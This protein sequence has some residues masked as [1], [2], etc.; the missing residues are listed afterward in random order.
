M[1]HDDLPDIPIEYLNLSNRSKNFLKNEGIRTFNSL[2]EFCETKDSKSTFYDP[3]KNIRGLGKKSLLEINSLINVFDCEIFF[4]ENPELLVLLQNNK[5]P[6]EFASIHIDR[7]D[8][9][10]RS[11]NALQNNSITNLGQL[12]LFTIEELKNFKNMGKKSVY[13]IKD[14][15]SKFNLKLNT[16]NKEDF[17]INNISD[18]IDEI[19]KKKKFNRVKELLLKRIFQSKTLNEVGEIAGVTRERIRQI[20]KD[21]FESL[22]KLIG[23]SYKK[24]ISDFFINNS[25]INGCLE[26]DRVGPSYSNLSKYLYTAPNPKVFLNK[27]F[28]EKKILKWQKKDNDLFFYNHA[29]DSLDEIVES[30]EIFKFILKHPSDN[31]E[32]IIS[33]FCLIKNQK[34]N[35]QYVL[36]KVKE[37]LA[38]GTSKPIIYAI[39]QLKK[40]YTYIS[41]KQI[42]NFLKE[43]LDKDI[44]SRDERSINNIFTSHWTEETASKVKELNLYMSKGFGNYFFLDKLGIDLNNQEEIVNSV[45]KLFEKNP[46]KNFNSDEFYNHLKVT[47]K[48]S[49][50]TLDKIDK[51][52]IDAILL[53]VE[54]ENN[55]LNY[56]GRSTWSCN[57]KASND[58][59]IE[60]YPSVI[61]I[62]EDR[63]APMPL[64]EIKKEMTKVRGYGTNFQLHTTLT[65]PKLIQISSGIW[66]LRD[67]DINVSKDQELEMVNQIQ[68]NFT[69][70]NKILD[71][72]DIKCFKESI[73]IDEDVSIF[74]LTRLLHAHIPVGR[75]RTPGSLI[76]LLKSSS[77]NP[78]NFC[79]YSP[80]IKDE[81]ASEYINSRIGNEFFDVRNNEDSIR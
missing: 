18:G 30:N 6:D 59:R 57:K 79:I 37:K 75:R 27:F 54:E 53:N 69:R 15:I 13:E 39:Q 21:F 47:G 35:T 58:K 72:H 43:S 77:K 42:K 74:Q 52:V 12:S 55:S 40:N 60:I 3:L 76:F 4:E 67:R 61:K 23:K 24:E 9:S 29:E 68:K 71:F 50:N 33:N 73:G 26:L 17:D 31:L 32:I 10:A 38:T 70:G 5:I 81:E 78:L 62:L 66:G 19:L 28:V 41:L 56:L 1:S 64:K 11:Y 14:K 80:E 46:N 45:L 51:Y 36:K 49:T 44:L 16:N 65:S 8:L 2:K 20:E 7:L 22:D 63:G 25:G 34:E 48:I